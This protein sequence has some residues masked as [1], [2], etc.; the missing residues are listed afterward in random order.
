MWDL[1][2]KIMLRRH[3]K[4][5]GKTSWP[6]KRMVSW[7]VCAVLAGGLLVG[8]SDREDDDLDTQSA[9]DDAAEDTSGGNTNASTDAAL[10][11]VSEIA[12]QP[13]STFAGGIVSAAHPLAAEAGAQVLENGGNAIDAAVVTQFVLNVVEPTSSGIGGGGFIGIYKADEGRV[14]YIDAREKAP[15]A[16]TSTQFLT[17]DPDCTGEET[18]DDRIGTFTEY[19]TSGIGVGVP[20]TLLGAAQALGNYGSGT[21]T[22]AQA[23]QPAIELAENGFA[24]N[25]R[26]ATLTESER[27]SFWPETSAKFRTSEGEPLSEGF[28]LV[29]PDLANTFRLIAE[30]GV[31][32]F[33]TGEMADAI[34][35]A[36]LR[37]R[38]EVGPEGAG[39]MSTED[40][41]A[42]LTDFEDNGIDERDPVV[43][44]YRGFTING[45]PPPSSGG[46]TVAQILECM[47][48]FPIGS[49][50][51]GFG[52]GS[53]ATLHVMVESMRLAFS[54]RS[55]WMGDND[56]LPLPIAG[57]LH[58]DY[59]AERC[60][61]IT[62]EARIADEAVVPGDPRLF[63]P[64]FANEVETRIN[65]GAD[66]ETG[67]DTTHFTVIDEDGNVVS[68]TST[69]EGTWGSGITV[70][71]Y[72][73]LL[74]N[75]LTDFNSVPQANDS[76]EEFAPGAND[77]APGKRPRSSMAPTI[78]LQN[79]EFVAA[80]GSPGGSTIINSVV[81]IT[82]NLID[83]GMSVQEAID[84][85]RIS[86][87][88][89]SIAYEEG[90]DESALTALTTLGHTLRDEPGAIGSVQAVTVEAST[91]LVSGGADDRRAGTV[92][93]LPQPQ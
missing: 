90:F 16:A 55:V 20:G 9:S 76:V 58:E 17:C 56:N 21:L 92:A 74:N 34:V 86:S 4:V 66:G 89:G 15:A 31:D 87:S 51:E 78:I 63:D 71:G 72:G 36:Q 30:E 37:S 13:D 47:E 42:Y 80:Y 62:A 53:A 77:V 19:A 84:A 29:Q 69:I 59:L 79:N 67:I 12:S 6:A 83:H 26:L 60:S 18:R 39:R 38:V 65:N 70:P 88:G 49:E 5:G 43:S 61:L 24:I 73:F 46:L 45:M 10:P 35:D 41:A 11:G 52:E 93:G 3:I 82:A 54:S 8:C 27:T 22:L 23:L 1:T 44:D 7:M 81:N 85:P 14:F 25:E 28:V 68:W 50:E 57:L 48:Q 33:Y 75:E 40:L 91:G 32:V 64:A 2:G